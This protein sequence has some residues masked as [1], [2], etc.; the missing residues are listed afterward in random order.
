[1]NSLLLF[2][3]GGHCLSV[4]DALDIH[5]YSKVGI[6]DCLKRVGQMLQDIPI[7]GSDVD[8]SRLRT[9]FNCAFITLGGVNAWRK[10]KALGEQLQQAMFD[11]PCIVHK[12]SMVSKSS[13]MSDGVYVG[14]LA[15]VNAAS[16]IGEQCIL[17]SGCIVEHDCVVEPYAHIA[18]GAV[19]CGGVK[20]GF[21]SHVGAGSVIREGISVGANS[22]VGAGSV[23]TKNIPDNVVAYGNPCKVIKTNG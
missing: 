10:R 1:M 5:D 8:I 3:G 19:L 4:L 16:K 13:Q 17:N 18:P 21:G 9:D 7:V 20:I 22:V 2:G 15:I 12:D 11:M 23:V 14:P 6:V